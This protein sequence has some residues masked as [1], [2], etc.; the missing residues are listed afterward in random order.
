[1]TTD[2]AHLLTETRLLDFSAPQIQQLITDRGWRALAPYDQIGAVHD[3]VR[4]E[5][6][7]GYNA[8]D[9]LPASRV[10]SDGYGQCN[11]KGILLMALLRVLGIPCRLHGFTI[12]KSLQ[13]GIVPELPYRFAPREI[14]HSWVE[15]LHQDRWITLEGFILDDPL[16]I[17]L[18]SRFGG[19]SLCAYGVGTAC[20]EA[21]AVTWHGTDTFI[22]STGITR[23]FGLFDTPDAF[24]ADHRQRL[25]IL[26]VTLYRFAIRHW[27]NARVR[28]MRAGNIPSIPGG[29]DSAPANSD[30]KGP[31]NAA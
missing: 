8:D 18:Q 23:D 25:G 22:Q 10:L 9:A 15:V 29:P 1:M 4:N 7:F 28:A 30:R 26:R 19:G 5:I 6:A 20:L 27:M 21:P 31:S 12:A 11:T 3:F 2:Y 24:F 16:L 17:A 14:V 13:R